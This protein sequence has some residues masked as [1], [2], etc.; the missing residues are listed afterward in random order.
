MKQLKIKNK[1]CNTL[2][3]LHKFTDSGILVILHLSLLLLHVVT[4]L[5]AQHFITITG[6]IVFYS[7]K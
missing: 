3:I 6:Y 2:V 7:K 4:L 5:K 1:Q